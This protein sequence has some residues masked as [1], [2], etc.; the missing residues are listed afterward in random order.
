[1][2]FKI[3]EKGNITMIQGDSGIIKVNGLDTNQNYL[4]Y[5]AIQDKDRNPVGQ[6]L[7]INSNNLSTVVFEL[8]G[9]YTDLLKVPKNKPYE[10]YYYGIKVCV[11]E[12]NFEDTL[13]LGEGSIG[14][15]NSIV[16]YPKKVEGI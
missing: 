6:E 13:I 8:T 14:S 2:A 15:I 11:R 16:V 5:L 3:D 4:V 9:D 10:I 1:M 7:C 12:D